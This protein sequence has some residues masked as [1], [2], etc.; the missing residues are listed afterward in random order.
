MDARPAAFNELTAGKERGILLQEGSLPIFEPIRGL[1][2]LLDLDPLYGANEGKVL[3]VVS[4]ADAEQALALLGEIAA[5]I[6]AGAEEH[7][8]KLVLNTAVNTFRTLGVLTS[9]P[10]SWTC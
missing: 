3:V 4:A 8:G 9:D 1:E 2:E 5:M 6:G 7:S 10:F